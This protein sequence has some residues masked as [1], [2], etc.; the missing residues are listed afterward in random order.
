M[1]KQKP[2][3]WSVSGVIEAPVEQ[4][5]AALLDLT[6][7]LSEADK[8]VIAQN[9]PEQSY[10][11]RPP[12]AVKAGTEVDVQHHSIATQGEWWYRGVT[13]VEPHSR[14]SLV[15]YRVT[16]V[17]PGVGWWAAQLVQGPEH[18]RSMKTILEQLLNTIGKKLACNTYT[19][20][21]GL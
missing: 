4:V 17:A 12:G 15:T 13:S 18:A 8:Q 19:P 9:P 21:C 20:G 10:L 16:N 14:G 6:P 2:A 7:E 1:R 5:W 3:Q 11:A